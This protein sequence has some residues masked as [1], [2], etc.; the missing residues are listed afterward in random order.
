MIALLRRKPRSAALTPPVVDR[1]PSPFRLVAAFAAGWLAVAA[2]PAG[3]TQCPAMFF[4]GSA[5]VI[6]NARLAAGSHEICYQTFA[7]TA[8]ALSRTGIWS[9]EH[10]TR[11]KVAAARA[12]GGRH[13]RWHADA[14][15]SGD[16]RASPKD[17][18]NSGY[19]RG[20]LSPS[21]DMPTPDADAETF[22]MA[23]VAPQVPH[24]NRGSWEQAESLTRDIAVY[25]GEIWVVTGVMFEG[26]D[27]LQIGRGVLVPTSFYKA[28][29]MPGRGAAVYVATNDQSPRWE[30]ISVAELK[31]RSGIDVFPAVAI[32][33]KTKAADLPMPGARRRRQR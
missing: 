30:V 15:L 2:V 24:L 22:T 7:T 17:Y 13:G 12:M 27:L 9:A 14:H 5:P 8:S 6:L 20:H 1:P 18:T 4:R 32:D 25:L 26:S 16:D 3:A 11:D 10:L 31:R 28:L 19:D 23:N 33:L 21:G 29:L